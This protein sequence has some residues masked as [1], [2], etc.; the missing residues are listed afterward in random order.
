MPNSLMIEM[1]KGLVTGNL[2]MKSE[3]RDYRRGT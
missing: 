2:E 3:M 1:G